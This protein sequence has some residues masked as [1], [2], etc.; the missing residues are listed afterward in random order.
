MAEV[1]H[2]DVLVT[3]RSHGFLF[4]P[5]RPSL[6]LFERIY[7]IICDLDLVAVEDLGHFFESRAA[8]F[9]VEDADKD[10]F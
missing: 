2:L 8:R 4:D 3:N 7:I 1:V 6:E 9:D 10:E 5:Q